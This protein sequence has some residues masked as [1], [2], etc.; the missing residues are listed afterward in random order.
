M[1]KKGAPKI[2]KEVKDFEKKTNYIS[3]IWFAISEI[4]MSCYPNDLYGAENDCLVS[5][6][7]PSQ[8]CSVNESQV[9]DLNG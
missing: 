4:K 9:Q 1:T 8:N 3:I 7:Y 5:E 6:W 2:L